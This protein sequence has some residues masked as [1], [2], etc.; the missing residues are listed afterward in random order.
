MHESRGGGRLALKEK[1]V[2]AKPVKARCRHW[3]ALEIWGT[4]RGRTNSLTV[5]NFTLL[6]K[7]ILTHKVMYIVYVYLCIYTY[8]YTH[9]YTY[10]YIYIYICIYI[11]IYMYIYM[12]IYI[13]I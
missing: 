8:I 2:K 12:Y 9:I 5:P 11:Y 1:K 10:I 7:D 4:H 3:S 6:H 13:H